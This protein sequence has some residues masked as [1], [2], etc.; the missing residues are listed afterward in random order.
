MIQ[1]LVGGL[2]P[3]KPTHDNSALVVLF[4]RFPLLPETTLVVKS[5]NGV[6]LFILNI[7]A[8]PHLA[9]SA[10]HNSWRLWRLKG[11]KLL[12]ST[13]SHVGLKG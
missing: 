4:K 2:I 12:I 13:T 3:V 9:W 11:E 7:G 5:R 10:L 8:G 6:S 1:P